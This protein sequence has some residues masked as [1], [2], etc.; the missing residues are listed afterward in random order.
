MSLEQ[1]VNKNHQFFKKLGTTLKNSWNYGSL[2][3]ATLTA[4]SILAFSCASSG[5][6]DQ[7]GC[8]S[9]Y[10]CKGA[11]VCY[12]GECV[13]PEKVPEDY[14][15]DF[16]IQKEDV[17][18]PQKDIVSQ[19]DSYHPDKDI[20]SVKDT[21]QPNP[22]TSKPDKDIYQKDLEEVCEWQCNNGQ[23]ISSSWICD[24]EDDCNNGEDEAES[25]CG[26]SGTGSYCDSC[27]DDSDCKEGMVCSGWLDN[28]SEYTVASWCTES[29]SCNNNSDCGGN[30]V[31]LL[32]Y[33][34]CTPEVSLECKNGDVWMKDSCNSWI[35]VYDECEGD[36]YCSQGSCMISGHDCAEIFNCLSNNCAE[37][38]QNCK[39]SCVGNAAIEA[40]LAFDSL[41]TC[42]ENNDCFNDDQQQCIENNC[43]NEYNQCFDE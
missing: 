5:G 7:G 33:N 22:D 16:S 26:S 19:K 39:Q 10:D 42:L 3:L 35:D 18:S 32:D 24:G 37:E 13:S 38:D 15:E 8:K 27:D 25:I 41:Y 20:I 2:K 31:C 17:S 1:N 14:E 43:L 28:S 34:T 21:Y 40:Q 23:C 30:Y 12:Q 29:E 9:N 11:R 36:Y 4:A 6:S